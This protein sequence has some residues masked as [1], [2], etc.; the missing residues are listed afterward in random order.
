MEEHIHARFE[1]NFLIFHRL[2]YLADVNVQEGYGLSENKNNRMIDW[3]RTVF[4][5]LHFIVNNRQ[6]NDSDVRHGLDIFPLIWS[7][8]IMIGDTAI[9]E[10][11]TGGMMVCLSIIS[12]LYSAYNHGLEVNSK[13]IHV[14]YE[15]SFSPWIENKSQ[16]DFLFDF[17]EKSEKIESRLISELNEIEQGLGDWTVEQSAS[18]FNLEWLNN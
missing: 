9:A 7:Q 4:N 17:L 2:N 18:L 5:D 10:S 16:S 11:S 15:H 1:A 13:N 8:A 3:S 14:R 6:S 12:S